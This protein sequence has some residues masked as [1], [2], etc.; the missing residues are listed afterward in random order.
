M[1]REGEF[2]KIYKLGIKEIRKHGTPIYIDFWRK[3]H[4]HASYVL[5]KCVLRFLVV[6]V[7]FWKYCQYI[8][9]N[10]NFKYMVCHILKI[11][12]KKNLKYL[13]FLFWK[14]CQN[15]ERKKK[16]N[17]NICC[18]IFQKYLQYN[19]NNYLKFWRCIKKFV[20]IVWFCLKKLNC[21]YLKI[22]MLEPLFKCYFFVIFGILSYEVSQP[23][24]SH[25]DTS[26]STRA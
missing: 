22:K 25:R 21:H 23:V 20:F 19:K 18:V 9:K 4:S 3:R 8:V 17:F 11:F 16:S 15:I 2:F 14:Y 24:T 5:L 10:I 26:I 12:S 6:N 13:V 1:W 7:I